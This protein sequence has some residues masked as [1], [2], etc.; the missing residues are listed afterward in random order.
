MEQSATDRQVGVDTRPDA[1]VARWPLSGRSVGRARR[2]L[3][4]TLS[5]WGLDHLT[6]PAELVLSELL[7]NAVRYART[8]AGRLVETRLER[9]PDGIRIEVH[10]ANDRL[11]QMQ[12][13]A[14][15]DEGGRGLA[16]VDVL[17][18]RRWGV[19]SRQGVGKLVWALVG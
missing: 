10:D 12:R 13:A 19:S 17:T 7:T 16:L 14:D 11:P 3:R 18:E 4:G 15:D 2:E 5:A 8:P 1:V 6:E 9:T